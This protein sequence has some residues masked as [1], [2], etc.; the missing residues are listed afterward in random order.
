MPIAVRLEQAGIA[1]YCPVITGRVFNC[2]YSA[3]A[4]FPRAAIPVLKDRTAPRERW[5]RLS[6]YSAL[7]I[8]ILGFIRFS[9]PSLN[10]T[11]L[12][13]RSRVC[14]YATLP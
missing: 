14:V 1:C 7:S 12:V 13:K 8:A 6:S 3:K 9:C 11:T 4:V 5:Q 2:Y 10:L